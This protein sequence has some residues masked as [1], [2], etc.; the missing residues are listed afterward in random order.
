MAN[1][2]ISVF[3][4]IED[5]PVWN[6]FKIYETNELSYILLTPPKNTEKLSSELKKAWENIYN[7]FIDFFGVSDNYRKILELKRE[8][9]IRETERI[10]YEDESQQTFKEVAQYEL[11]VLL[12]RQTNQTMEDMTL[13]IEERY[14]FP[15]DEKKV[16]VKKYYSYL[17]SLNKKS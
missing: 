5:M 12:K 7:Q 15:I 3:E 10:I 16:S 11:D 1:K 9:C 6:W 14:R 17:K 2:K 4:S 13:A 8:I